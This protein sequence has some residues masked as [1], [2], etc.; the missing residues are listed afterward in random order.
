[1]FYVPKEISKNKKEKKRGKN[2]RS[3]TFQDSG[4]LEYAI[5]GTAFVLG[6]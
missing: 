2:K 5:P 4:S 1:M 6:I 3:V